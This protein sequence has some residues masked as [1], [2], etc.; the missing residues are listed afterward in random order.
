MSNTSTTQEP[1]WRAI[2]LIGVLLTAGCH[3]RR[4]DFLEGV[5]EDC[6][7]GD[8][9]AC[10]LLDAL[11]HPR[12]ANEIQTPES[13]KMTLTILKGIDRARSAPRF[14]YPFVP[15]MAVDLQ[16]WATV[17]K[18][19]PLSDR[20]CRRPNC[21]VSPTSPTIYATHGSS[22]ICRSLKLL[23]RLASARRAFTFGKRIIAGPVTRICRRCARC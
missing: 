4:P 19:S 13:S 20:T 9:W 12:P 5:R 1:V 17:T 18:F 22:V 3:S 10:N 6:T 11:H 23:N 15:P 21:P 2:L 7:T 8:Q 14:G 16:I